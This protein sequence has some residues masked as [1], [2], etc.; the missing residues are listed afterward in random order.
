MRKAAQIAGAA[1][2]AAMLLS[3]CG[4]SSSEDKPATPESS[5]PSA[6]DAGSKPSGDAALEGAWETKEGGDP[7]ILVFKNGTAAL[8]R[9]HEAGCLGKVES[10]AGLSMVALKCTDGDTS[11][12]MGRLK[13]GADGKSLTVTW[14][15]GPTEK[16]Q[17]AEDGKVKIPDLPKLPSGAPN[18]G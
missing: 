13:P 12:T 16:Y 14:K 15:G 9:G 2:L 18:G 17:R 10:M 4:S 5:A 1:A 6:P 7:L 3:G 8:S 11:R